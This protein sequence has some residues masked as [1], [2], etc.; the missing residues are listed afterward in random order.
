MQVSDTAS[1]ANLSEPECVQLSG[2]HKTF[3]P[4]AQSQEDVFSFVSVDNVNNFVYKS[5]KWRFFRGNA[6][7]KTFLMKNIFVQ[8]FYLFFSNLFI[9]L[10]FRMRKNNS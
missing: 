1:C 3:V 8:I 2:M 10:I 6:M 7:W 4:E 5:G 9:L